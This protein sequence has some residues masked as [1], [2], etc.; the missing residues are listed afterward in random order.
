M[1]TEEEP[2]TLPDSPV[3]KQSR[4]YAAVEKNFFLKNIYFL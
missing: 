3:S 2:K 4:N 1:K